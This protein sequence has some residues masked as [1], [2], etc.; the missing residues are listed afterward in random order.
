MTGKVWLTGAGPSDVGL[1]T[2]KAV[3][4]I[5]QA[6]A[7]VYDSLVGQAVLALIPDT[8]VCYD[9]GKRAG[10]HTMRQEETN[11]LLVELAQEG[12]RVVRLKGGDPFL[13]GR[14]G[15]EAH[16]LEQAGIPYE[17]IPGI[18]SAIAVPAY[19]GIP[20]T[21]RESS[22][23][24]HIITGHK[25]KDEALQL[26]FQALKEAGG[27]LVFL[28][29]ISALPD[30]CGGL[31]AAGMDEDT[32]AALA[33]LGTTAE[34]Y[35]IEATLKSLPEIARKNRPKTPAVIVIGDVCK[36]EYRLPFRQALPLHG[37]R[38]YLTRPQDRQEP[39]A[40]Q[41]RELGAEVIGMPTIR[42]VI[43]EDKTQLDQAIREID[44]Y[45][46]LTFTSQAGVDYFFD[47]LRDCGKDIR[48]IG[49]I[50]IAAIGPST[51]EALLKRGLCTDY[52][53]TVYDGFH[54]GRLLCERAEKNSRILLPRAEKANPAVTEEIGRRSDL[55]VT[56]IPL[57]RT[58]YTKPKL[59]DPGEILM[60]EQ[61]MEVIFTSSSTV[62]G[63]LAA[64]NGADVSGVKAYCIGPSTAK[65]AADAGMEV[66]VA[67]K[68]GTEG[69]LERICPVYQTE[70]N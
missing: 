38:F 68:A 62:K 54:L 57:Y 2:Q 55:S 30:I 26:P 21:H 25:K 15:E 59:Q 65:T 5:K 31:L 48:S 53:P 45:Q 61:T 4:V 13:F 69:L 1:L 39:L 19:A 52:M 23:M 47:Y 6:D 50:K 11:A 44:C 28:M 32:P 34:E 12:K 37:R 67:E 22:S 66:T 17:V 36:Q 60:R 7:V 40:G 14:G 63:F 24:L 70:T 58:E 9:A 20:V 41:L 56:E 10:N 27:T 43:C 49:A 64:V 35:L 8:A 42:T 18:T 33:G 46:I 16:V 3:Q 29:G 51:A